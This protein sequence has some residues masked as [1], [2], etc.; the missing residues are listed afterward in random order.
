[1]HGMSEEAWELA[2]IERLAETDFWQP[3]TGHDIA[4][5]SG[6]RDTWADP[7]VRPWVMDALVRLKCRPNTCNKRLPI[8]SRRPRRTPSQRTIGCTT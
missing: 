7:V 8:S 5:G 1:M 3:L 4:P 6:L 2:A